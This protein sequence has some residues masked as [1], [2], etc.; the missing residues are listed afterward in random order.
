MALDYGNYGIFLIMGNAG[1][2][3]STVFGKR[4]DEILTRFLSRTLLALFVLG[5]PYCIVGNKLMKPLQNH[6]KP[7]RR[8]CANLHNPQTQ[9]PKPL[10][11]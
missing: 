5:F 6:M 1:F 8:Y 7:L 9:S 10:N 3:T 4:S 2:I 11:P